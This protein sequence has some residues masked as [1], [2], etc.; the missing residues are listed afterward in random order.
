MKT[1]KMIASAL[2]A[3]VALAASNAQTVPS[4]NAAGYI[5]VTCPPDKFQ[6]IQ[7]PFKT[8]DGTSLTLS[9]V[10]G[11]SMPSLTRFY[12]WDATKQEFD[13]FTY[14]AGV[15]LI[16]SKAKPTEGPIMNRGVG[17]YIKT[18]ASAHVSDLFL[19]GEVPGTSSSGQTQLQ[20]LP[21]FNAIGFP[22][23]VATLLSESGLDTATEHNDRA[24]VWLPDA[25][26]FDVATRY[27]I[28]TYPLMKWSK[29]FTIPAGGVV[30]VK[31]NGTQAGTFTCNV[32]YSW[33]N[34]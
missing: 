20:A 34:N 16:D 11:T 24:Y 7:N 8:F 30:F 28:P 15:G 2:F 27:V 10:V 13:S 19:F 32:P 4:V 26:D 23:P 5:K 25:Q 22:Y 12:V 31:K 1:M 9:G 33:P 14:I 6:F 21:G 18:P 3:T 29:D 17:F